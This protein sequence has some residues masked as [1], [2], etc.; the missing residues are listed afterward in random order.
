MTIDFQ[1]A[2]EAGD[3]GALRRVPKSDLHNHAV[4]G[5]DRL[6]LKEQTG[7]DI[8]PLCHPLRSMEEMHAWVGEN[9]GHAFDGAAGRLVA[10]EATFVAALKDGVSRL[11]VGEDV[12]AITLFEGSAVTL[13]AAL[14]EIHERAAPKVEWIPQLGI[15]RH[16]SPDAISRSRLRHSCPSIAAQGKPDCG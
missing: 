11:E 10:F 15:S 7:L 2:L 4:L 16:C 13:T 1:S 3:I 12:W 8:E 5:G 9:I 14:R 6:W